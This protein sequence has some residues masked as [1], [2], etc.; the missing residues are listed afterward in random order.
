MRIYSG[1]GIHVVISLFEAQMRKWR[2]TAT[3]S[4]SDGKCITSSPSDTEIRRKYQSIEMFCDVKKQTNKWRNKSKRRVVSTPRQLP[5][6]AK[7]PRSLQNSLRCKRFP[8]VSEQRTRR[9]TG[10][11]VLTARE[12]E[13]VPK[14][15]RGG[16]GEGKEETLTETNRQTRGF[17]KPCS[18]ADGAPDSLC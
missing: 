17:W 15:E 8:L 18:P 5:A 16:T 11:S 7:K 14:D 13:R 9:K 3:P 10:F 12:M 6:A 1:R 4:R 2:L